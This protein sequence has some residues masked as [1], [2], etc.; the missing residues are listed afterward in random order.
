MLVENTDTLARH[1]MQ[2]TS[3]DS[4][5]RQPLPDAEFNTELVALIPHMRA[6]AGSLC[7][8]RATADDIAQ[9]ALAKAWQNRSKFGAGTNLKAWAFRI[10]RN[11]F[12]SLKRRDWRSNPLDQ[13]VAEQT[14]QAND[15]PEDTVHI[16][17][18]R[19]A[20]HK[21]SDDHREA[22]VLV[23]ASGMSYQEAGEICGVATGTMKSR[24]NRARKALEEVMSKGNFRVEGDTIAPSDA[25]HA[26]LDEADKLA[27]RDR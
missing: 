8:N 26:I 11:E 15:N 5:A 19:H 6:F 25:A 23:G 7:A 12:Y 10:L 13:T 1:D 22:I 9:D 17:E 18:V 16:D 24:V 21:L 20:L 4:G 3:D 27:K 2:E 14:L